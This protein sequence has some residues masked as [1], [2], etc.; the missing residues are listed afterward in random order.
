M[1]KKRETI[2]VFGSIENTLKQ[3]PKYNPYQMG[4]GEHKSVKYKSRAKNKEEAR[5]IIREYL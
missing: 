3:M 1:S 2:K 5:Q 4:Y